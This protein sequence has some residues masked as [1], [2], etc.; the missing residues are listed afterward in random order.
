MPALYELAWR[1]LHALLCL[2]RTLLWWLRTRLWKWNLGWIYRLGRLVAAV[3]V[4]AA[5]DFQKRAAG[6][7]EGK[8]RV[9]GGG[10]GAGAAAR[11]R[12]RWRADARSLRK[13]PVH[14]GLL[15]AD[16]EQEEE[17]QQREPGYVEIANLVVWCMAVG[18]SYVSVYDSQGIFKRNNY[19]LMEE[20]LKQQQEL[21]GFDCSKYSELSVDKTESAI[22]CQT[23]V[24]VLSPEDGKEDIVRA[25]REFCQLVAQQQRQPSDLSVKVFDS[26]LRSSRDFPEPDLVLKFGPMDSTLG[27]LPWHLRLTEI[28]SLPSYLS[29]SY[30]DFFSALHHYAAC[31]QRLGK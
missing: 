17:Q 24:R 31:E 9:H 10:Q 8:G 1:F 6:R 27:F 23:A 20:I 19:R 18:I 14:V 5:F 2:Q 3:L 30:S 13:L 4:P 11:W 29:I 7:G 15:V 28:I 22:N 12:L 25:A 26:L 21:L 16:E